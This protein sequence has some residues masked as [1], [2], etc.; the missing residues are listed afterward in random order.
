MHQAA[1]EI[2]RVELADLVTR[3]RVVAQCLIAV[4]EALWDIKSA[5]VF[6]VQLDGC[7]LEISRAFWA[8][9]YDD[10]ENRAASATHQ[11]RLGRWGKLE[12]HSTQ[13]ALLKVIRDICLCDNWIESVGG[14]FFLAES[15]CEKSS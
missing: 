6:L 15:S 13:R 2:R 7:I 12:V 8:K 1:L 5:A 4:R 10:V 3:F 9:I 11:L 14:E